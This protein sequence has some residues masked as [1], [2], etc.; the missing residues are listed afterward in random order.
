MS[1]L[2]RRLSRAVIVRA[3]TRLGELCVERNS[4]VEIA[5]YGGTV[6]MLAYDCREATKDI[7]AIFHPPDVVEPLIRQ[8]A[9]EQKLPEDW[10][11][12]GV[13]TFVAKREEKI[14]FAQLKIPG[15][16]IT[17]PSA[18]YLLAMKCIAARLPTPTR[19]GDLADIKYLL[20]QLGI[21]SVEEVDAI[22][23]DYYGGRQLEAGKR[24]LVEELIKEARREKR[25][26]K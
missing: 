16:A 18:R 7:D 9:R 11:N 6:M 22:V 24:W 15:L 1:K 17:R 4:R 5:I 25:A 8:V 23:G 19:Q 3:L 20:A 13:E 26:A 2:S 21:D 12:N 10:M 14:E